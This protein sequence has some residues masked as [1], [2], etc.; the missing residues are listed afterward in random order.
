MRMEGDI[1]LANST[2]DATV[3]IFATRAGTALGVGRASKDRP[4]RRDALHCSAPNE[5]IVA[6]ICA[7]ELAQYS[8]LRS[9]ADI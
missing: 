3:Y 8:V 6:W 9:D 5:D 7:V 2:S 4:R 1:I